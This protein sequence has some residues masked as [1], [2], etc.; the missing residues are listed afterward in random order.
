MQYK[1]SSKD[2]SGHTVTVTL[3]IPC[4]NFNQLLAEIHD[5]HDPATSAEDFLTAYIESRWPIA[6][7][8]SDNNDSEY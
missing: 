8:T 7:T 2:Y 3:E 1:E 6:N 5:W 4:G